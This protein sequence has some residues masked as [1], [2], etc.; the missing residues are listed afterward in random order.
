M[1]EIHKLAQ[2]HNLSVVEDACH[3]LGTTYDSNRVG[4]GRHADMSAF[5]FHPVK[6]MTT[7]E[8]GLVTTGS[9][10]LAAA[11]RLYRN[12]GLERMP[13]QW[14]RT[15][16]AFDCNGEPNPWYY[17]M[18]EPGFNYRLTDFQCALGLSQLDKLDRF[19]SHRQKLVALYDS[20][21][22]PFAPLVQPAERT[23]N[24][25]TSWHLYIALFD[26]ARIGLD[27]SAVMKQLHA[28]GIGSQV[29]Y[30]PVHQQP[31][32]Q[33]RQPDVYLPGADA[34]FAHCLSLPL[35]AGMQTAD[36]HRVVDAIRAIVGS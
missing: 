29:H 8:G 6:T 12:H 5:S 1:K 10:E 23:A 35:S 36:V 16:A 13:S 19:I 7:G 25:S 17:E 28:G 24:T 30:I 21:L 4:D 22:T 3:A 14:S 31:Y 33:Q 11:L 34:Y 9:D 2:D 27:R 20:L 32:Y 26:F 18:S 15:D